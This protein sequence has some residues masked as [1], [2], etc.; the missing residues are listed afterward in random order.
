VDSNGGLNFAAVVPYLCHEHDC[1]EER[2]CGG[3]GGD[4]LTS[5]AS[6]STRKALF[7]V[8]YIASQIAY[9]IKSYLLLKYVCVV[10]YNAFLTAVVLFLREC[11][12]K[13]VNRREHFNLLFS[14]KGLYRKEKTQYFTITKINW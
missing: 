8:I 14:I 6:Y 7:A 9:L 5:N 11:K 12:L 4:Y 13:F 2:S 1:S 10:R 3:G